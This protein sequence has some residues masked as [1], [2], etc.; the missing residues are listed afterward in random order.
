MGRL[1]QQ[2]MLPSGEQKWITAGTQADLCQKC[3]D[4]GNLLSQSIIY[5]VRKAAPLFEEYAWHWFDTYHVKRVKG[6]TSLTAKSAL[7]KHL[8]AEFRG[9]RLDEITHDEIQSFFNDRMR[10]SHSTQ[11]KWFDILRQIFNNAT[12]D[13]L[14]IKNVMDSKRYVLSDSKKERQP[15]SFDELIDILD[16]LHLL[17]EKERLYL[18]LL[19]FTGVRR[20]EA[21][22]LEWKDI[23]FKNNEIHITKAVHFDDGNTATIGSTKSVSGVR[24]IPL[25]DKLAEALKGYK[26]NGKYIVSG[27][28]MLSE[29]MY[30]RMWD[31]IGQTI[32][33]HG[34]TAHIFRHTFCTF[35]CYLNGCKI[36][37]LQSIMGH[38][39]SE[40]TMDVY[41]KAT[42]NKCSRAAVEELFSGLWRE[43]KSDS[44]QDFFI[45]TKQSVNGTQ[46]GTQ[47]KVV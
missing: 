45:P 21:L 40:I 43:H 36:K 13:G 12:E 24:D 38:S 35:A 3:F 34:A 9:K 25:V 19:A 26:R 7:N 17:N 44:M 6:R 14:I 15:L 29:T 23:D 42:K 18:L 20:G 4:A 2:I 16:H 39:T 22:A 46:Y 47:Q 30:Q 11:K 32:D 41:T 37:E 1:K 33:L 8:I 28:N 31:R 5:P 27:E 10:Y